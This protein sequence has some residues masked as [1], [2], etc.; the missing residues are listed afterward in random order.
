M[1]LEAW[2]GDVYVWVI[3]LRLGCRLRFPLKPKFT[4]LAA[5]HN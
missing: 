1:A 3:P 4:V 2:G 5:M